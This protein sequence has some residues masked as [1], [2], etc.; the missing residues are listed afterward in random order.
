MTKRSVPAIASLLLCLIVPIAAMLPA[1]SALAQPAAK[2]PNIVFVLMDNLGYG[3]VG[4]YGG[5]IL[6]GAPTPR[7][8]TI[9]ELLSDQGLDVDQGTLYPLLRRLESQGLLQSIW[10]LEEARPRRYYKMSQEGE[11]IFANLTQE[12]RAMVL[13]MDRLLGLANGGKQ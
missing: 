3:E 7:E 6:R 5:G 9:A 2:K 13:M 1:K 12:W 4:V 11:T 8:L 10:K